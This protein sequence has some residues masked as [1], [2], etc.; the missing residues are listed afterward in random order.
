MFLKS[1]GAALAAL[2]LAAACGPQ[3][4]AQVSSL[5]SNVDMFMGPADAKV[6]VIEYGSPTCPGC[7]YWH[8]NF[9]EEM[10]RDYVATNKIKFVFREFAIHG[11]IDAA[12][13]SIARCTGQEDFFKVLDE[14]YATQREIVGQAQNGK[15][16]EAMN[17]LGAKFQ[18]SPDQVKSCMNDPKNI[19]RINDVGA[20]TKQIGVSSTP[21]FFVNGQRAPDDFATP[22]GMARV[23]DAALAA[24]A[25]REISR[26][27]SRERLV[28]GARVARARAGGGATRL[29]R[30][31]GAGGARRR[32]DFQLWRSGAASAAAF[33]LQRFCF[34]S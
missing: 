24:S 18:L 9:L 20:Y 3:G 25:R 32:E 11:A 4:R 26:A 23:L 31:L 2:T 14:A 12:I 28:A 8:D 6:T 5:E 34:F 19:A 29:G 22:A 17:A 13:F 10:K 16:I 7:K 21:T 1:L 33:A 30:R 27:V 15:S